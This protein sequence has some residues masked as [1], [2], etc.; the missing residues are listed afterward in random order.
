M[1][2]P[3]LD[4]LDLERHREF[5]GRVTERELF[6]AAVSAAEL[7]FN[8][9]YVSGPGGVGKTTLLREFD[10][11]CEQ[12]GIPALFVDGR[13]V[14]PS[15]GTFSKVLEDVASLDADRPARRVILVD[16]Y[17]ELSSLRAWIEGDF[18]LRLPDDFL[19]V[20]AGCDPPPEAWRID[21][22]WRSFIRPLRL[23]NLSEEESREYLRRREVPEEQHGDIL[24]FTH[25]HP[26][27]LS[28]VADVF[29]QRPG[30][31]FRPE[32]SPDVIRSLLDHFVRHVPGPAHRAAL[33]SCAL[34]RHTTETLLSRMLSIPDV[35][36]LF[37]WLRNLTFI[38]PGPL[39]LFPH[40]AA[41]EALTADLRWRNPDWHAELHARARSYYV[42]RLKQTRGLEQ[43]KALFDYMHLHR[44]NPVIRPFFE[45]RETGSS[46]PEPM[47]EE[48]KPR[49]LEMVAAHEGEESALLAS[50]WMDSQPSN[51]VLH[52]DPDGK[53]GGFLLKVAL[54]DADEAD[55][56][57]DP[58]VEA[59]LGYLERSAPLRAGESAILFR[60]WMARESYQEV[61]ALQSLLFVNVAQHYLATP[62]LAFTLFP[63]AEPDFWARAFAYFELPRLLEAD[64]E[65]GGKRY[66][67]YSR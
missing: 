21:P 18:L 15:P 47:R 31:R 24:G 54:H 11:L 30:I 40:A 4:R 27:A 8:V 45:W 17:E 61:S 3:L 13:E 48:D 6:S 7:P 62:R 9:L 55:R 14:E 37:E 36:E 39:G 59:A 58:A 5:V 49:L 26:L 23:G 64:F 51:V 20:I 12:A 63:V 53:P 19:L 25:G 29:D 34:A 10:H 52:R 50:R 35:H 22:G 44:D 66:G 32:E 46:S 43:Q 57:A 65:V 33:E 38:E 60:F 28:L 42:S 2:S 67:V 16:A 1:T 41:R 56:G